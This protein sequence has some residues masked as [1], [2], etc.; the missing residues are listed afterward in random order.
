MM[1]RFPVHRNSL[2]VK[3]LIGFFLVILLLI[4]FNILSFTFFKENIKKEII[5]HNTLN[6]K[7]TV[8]SYEKQFRLVES[9]MLRFYFSD[10]LLLLGNNGEQ[11][12]YNA[13]NAVKTEINTLLSNEMLHLNNLFVFFRNHPLVIDK[14]GLD[15]ASDLFSK[16]YVS[17]KYNAAFW[18]QQFLEEYPHRV[19]PAAEF[20]ETKIDRT[21]NPIGKMFPFV[22]K[23]R[24]NNQYII[25][26]L[27]DAEAM[28]RTFH[29]SGHDSFLIMDNNKQ[30]IYRAYSEKE[31][32]AMN[33]AQNALGRFSYS[34][35]QGYFERSDSYYFYTQ[36]EIS[37]LTYVNVIPVTSITVQVERLTIL[38]LTLLAVAV[39][40][41]VLI[42]ILLSIKFNNPIQRMVE[43]VQNNGKRGNV[44]SKIREF[45]LISTNLAHMIDA[46]EAMNKDL[47][48]KNKILE[49]YGYISKI[50]NTYQWNDV[51][52]LLET[53]KPFYLIV[54]QLVFTEQFRSLMSD[55]QAKAA[56]YIKEY[57]HIE[58]S[59]MFQDAVTVQMEKN[60]ISTLIF[61]ADN[62]NVVQQ[63]LY[64][65]KEVFDR[66]R[67]TCY[68]TIA[69]RPILQHQADIT[70]AYE[71]TQSM[72]QRR[73]LG[74][75]TQIIT[76]DHT[77]ENVYLFFTALEQELYASLQ[78]GQGSRAEELVRR[79]LLQLEERQASVY[80]FAQFGKEVTMKVI[81]ALLSHNVDITLLLSTHNPFQNVQECASR[82]EF[83]TLF[84]RMIGD[85]VL[86]IR[87]RKEE[88]DPIRDF[89]FDYVEEHYGE[90]ISLELVADKLNLSRS[91]L[92]TYFRE[93]TGMTFTD[94]LNELRII[95]AK[96]MLCE[97][98]VRIQDVAKRIG[99]H[100]VNS[101]IRMFKRISGLTPGEFRRLE[102]QKEMLD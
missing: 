33:V 42:S 28:F 52:D 97:R 45:D 63:M 13:M 24:F 65:L 6:L 18:K 25:T 51:H 92:S 98:D 72:I 55:E 27:L 94:Y 17:E 69:F 101:F 93:K 9:V 81:K 67:D 88:Q 96:E 5:D 10:R 8:D 68:L 41:S 76:E 61:S 11:V 60:R 58:I 21:V 102:L 74:K 70:M 30:T 80:Q 14:G 56:N 34:D 54:F 86:L 85:A 49:N 37:G 71:Q 43:M 19:F 23:N 78:L 57:I 87:E 7:N 64:K 66:D 47:T 36:G 62:P 15:N 1:F 100:N 29:Y 89:V 95:R 48:R 12:D 73:L 77:E 44:R 46:N 84:R 35:S 16:H 2:F 3:L 99:Y 20:R 4:S 39:L 90:D 79:S 22:V 38:L 26:A 91:Y 59:E 32:D 40:L 83:E 31:T 75:E 82:E 50:N 53:S